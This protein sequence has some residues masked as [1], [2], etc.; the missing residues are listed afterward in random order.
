LI[1][2]HYDELL[3][4]ELNG[5]YRSLEKG[6]G[7]LARWRLA[8]EATRLH[9]M[10]LEVTELTERAEHNYFDNRTCVRV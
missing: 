4:R 8:R 10:L 2:N 3:T 6:T 5:V 1:L 7:T 9:T